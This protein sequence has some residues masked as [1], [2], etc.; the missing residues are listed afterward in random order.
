MAQESIYCVWS[1]HVVFVLTTCA[2]HSC[3]QNLLLLLSPGDCHPSV[4]YSSSDTTCVAQLEGTVGLSW[5][6]FFRFSLRC[7]TFGIV[8]QLSS[9]QNRMMY[10]TTKQSRLVR[11][12]NCR[13]R[14][15]SSLQATNFLTLSRAPTTTSGVEDGPDS[16]VDQIIE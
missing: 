14:K 7:L 8:P 6:T 2:F 1:F 13:H 5:L 12:P 10:R 9:L 3:L 15:R 16:D 11:R 4:I